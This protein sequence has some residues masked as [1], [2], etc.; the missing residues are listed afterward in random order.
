MSILF[1]FFNS[2]KKTVK[3]DATVIRRTPSS[4]M[5]SKL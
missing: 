3:F 1:V 5:G 2:L 4:Y